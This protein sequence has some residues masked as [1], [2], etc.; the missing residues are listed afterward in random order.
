MKFSC[1]FTLNEIKERWYALLYDPTLSKYDTVTY[2]CLCVACMLYLNWPVNITLSKTARSTD[3][4][5]GIV[6]QHAKCER[7]HC[8]ITVIPYYMY[9]DL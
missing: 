2:I 6:E 8:I 1:K 7:E 3:S 9:Q 4:L 5:N